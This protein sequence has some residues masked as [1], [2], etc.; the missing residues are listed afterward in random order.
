MSVSRTPQA[1]PARS[2]AALCLRMV[3]P[4]PSSSIVERTNYVKGSSEHCVWAIL[5]SC[6][7]SLQTLCNRTK[8]ACMLCATR[9][10]G[11][12][13]EDVVVVGSL[14]ITLKP[15]IHFCAASC[16][17]SLESSLSCRTYSELLL[18]CDLILGKPPLILHSDRANV[19]QFELLHIA[20]AVGH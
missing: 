18:G 14:Q 8:L 9:K 3:S 1:Q 2:L 17:T 19:L 12:E 13:F 11:G 15:C 5:H 10:P 20:V 7:V 4:V 6:Q 16:S